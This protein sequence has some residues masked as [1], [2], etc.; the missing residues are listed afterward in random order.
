MLMRKFYFSLAFLA[1]ALSGTTMAKAD[2]VKPYTMDFNKTVST[3][4]H[5][6]KVAP[7]WGHKVGSYQDYYDAYYVNY[8]Y[9]S[10]GGRDGSGAISVEDQDHVGEGWDTHSITDLLVTP[11]I[12]GKASIYVKNRTSSKGSIKFYQVTSNNGTFTQG[13][14]ITVTVPTLS[15]DEWTKVELPEQTDAMIGIRASNVIIDDFSADQADITLTKGLKITRNSYTGKDKADCNENGKFTLNFKSYIENTGEVTLTQGMEGYDLSIINY[16]TPEKVLYTVPLTKTLEPGDKDTLDI[17]CEINYDDFS[18]RGRIDVKENITSTST[19]GFWIEPVPYKPVITL[20]N[21]DGRIDN[22]QTFTWGMVNAS[23]PKSFTLINDGAAP[24]HVTAVNVP[25]GFVSS[26]TEPF[27]LAAHA[28]SVFTVDMNCDNAGIYAGDVTIKGDNADDFTFKV[29]GTVLDPSK[30]FVNFEDQKLPA[31][32]Y[33]EDQWSIAQREYA[34]SS[35]NVYLLANNRQTTDDKFVTPLLKVEE[36]EKMS[37]DVARNYYS[38]AGDGVFLNVYYSADRK[39]W[40]LARKITADELSTE[41][42]TYSFSF[43]KLTTFVIDNIPAGNYYI[44][45]GAGYTAI[46]NIYGFTQVEVAHDWMISKA[47]IPNTATVNNAYTAKV[48]L[49]NLNNVDETANS[50]TATLYA[51]GTAVDS[52]KTVDIAAGYGTDFSFTYTPHK[53]GIVKTYIEF[54]NAA[55]GYT[56][57]SDTID[58]EVAK[59]QAS[60]I[61][62]VGNNNSTKVNVPV[63]WNYADSKA[64]TDN[65]YGPEILK[66]FGLKAGDKITSISYTGKPSS[67][68]TLDDVTL[69][70]YVGMVDSTTFEAGKNFESLTKFD[71]YN[72]QKVEFQSGQG[73]PLVINFATPLVWDGT[74]A[75]RIMNFVDA[76]G[77]YINVSY[78]T[79]ENYQTGYVFTRSIENS[80]SKSNLAVAEFKIQTE[81]S[82]VSGKVTCGD[83][84]V[85]DATVT[86]TS[87]EVIYSSKTDNEGAYSIPV[88]QTDKKYIMTVTAEGYYNYTD[89]TVD[90]T[91]SIEKNIAIKQ[92]ACEVSGKVTYR[93]TGLAGA[94]VSLNSNNQ[95]SDL[96]A[97]TDAEGNYTVEGV[98]PNVKYLIK[99][100]ANKFVDYVNEDSIVITKDSVL[101]DIEMV[102]AP[103]TVSGKVTYRNAALAN[104]TVSLTRKGNAIK[105]TTDAEGNY[106]FDEIKADENYALNVTADKFVAYAATDSVNFAAD[107]TLADIQLVRQTVS[108]S[109]NITWQNTVIS[110]AKVSLNS[111]SYN[112]EATTDE[113]GHYEITDVE[114]DNNYAVEVSAE[115]FD[116]Y[117]EKDSISVADTLKKDIELTATTVALTVSESGRTTFSSDRAIDFSKTEGVKAYVITNVEGKFVTLKEV[118]AVPAHTGVYIEATEGNYELSPVAKADDVEKN[119][120]VATDADYTIVDADLGKIWALTFKDGVSAFRSEAN[121]TVAKDQAYLKVESSKD[122]IYIYSTDGINDVRING[123]DDNTQKYNLGGQKIGQGYKGIVILNGKKSVRK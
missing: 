6:F 55:D 93:N 57:Y 41:R 23:S 101:T 117:T 74:S 83:A 50:Y 17:V 22:D 61:I 110:G 20:R 2:I 73:L 85:A 11:K 36:G 89:S 26:I 112:H 38:T 12:T 32:S 8:S 99:V 103:V 86:L 64:W 21:K 16:K 105:T 24:L 118:T 15:Q 56:V 45:F 42:A 71:I 90:V 18:T 44:G 115:G 14:E 102:K 109:G 87:G 104:A 68:K 70:S 3:S 82:V 19:Y 113:N 121:T 27:T 49:K 34:S 39:H 51:D 92:I 122:V 59:E 98:L 53:D 84:A 1:A 91:T 123:T 13:D 35:D 119:L 54:K 111:N 63:Y 69:T 47:D 37:V 46:D 30:F 114:P 116:T 33:Q 60:N 58:V 78:P 25:E 76:S 97:T 95:K 62:T 108:V 29:S 75:I 106:K 66:T 94:T 81:P 5:D 28:D 67:S 43:S 77:K 96:T 120:L 88:I 100:T 48:N 65:L 52:A 40:T 72:H 7:G 80:P 31:G 79:D 10:T 107:T 9:T 4:A